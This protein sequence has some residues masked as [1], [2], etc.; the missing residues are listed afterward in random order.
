MVELAANI[1]ADGPSSDPYEPDKAQIRAWGTWV[2]G[3]INAFTSTGGL[4]YSSKAALDADL[5]KPANSM[6]WVIGDPVAAD[7][8]VYGKV[9]ASGAGSWT[10]RSDLPFSFIVASDAGAGTPNTIQAT[11]SIPVSGSALV[12]MNIFEANT[13]SPVTVSFNSG[14]ALTIKTNSGDDVV[15]GGL[16]AGMIVMGI[17]SGST[18]RLVSDQASAAVLAAAEAAKNAAQAAQAAAEAA[19]AGV[20]LPPAVANTYL[21]QKADASGYETKTSAQVVADLNSMP[22]QIAGGDSAARNAVARFGDTIDIREFGFDLSGS[23]GSETANN[24]AFDRLIAN[25]TAN[26]GMVYRGRKGDVIRWSAN[27]TIPRCKLR[28]EGAKLHWIGDLS[29][30][31]APAL[32]LAQYGDFDTLLTEVPV[33]GLFRRVIR[34][35]GD[36]SGDTISVECENQVNN[37]GGNNLDRA[38]ALYGHRNHVQRVRTKNVDWGVL[39][40]GDGGGG[41]PQQDTYLGDFFCE[42]FVGGLYIRNVTRYRDRG[43]LSKIKSANALP[44]PG[45]NAVTIE[46]AVESQFGPYQLFD[47][48]EHNI[49]FG[50]RTGGT[51]QLMQDCSL[52]GLVSGRSGQ[53]GLKVWSGLNTDIISGLTFG[54]LDIFD[55]GLYAQNDSGS[56][57]FND[58]GV[59]IQAV[60]NSVFGPVNIYARNATY[61]S[62]DGGYF[63]Q[64][65]NV[66]VPVLNARKASRNG[67]RIS[68]YNGN[69]T[70]PN[71]TNTLRFGMVSVRDHLAEGIYVQVPTANMRDVSI[72]DFDIVGGTDV[73]RWEGASNRAAQPCYFRGLGRG[74]SGTLFNVPAG[75]NLKTVS[76]W[77]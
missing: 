52:A 60:R 3:I 33:G 19:A 65:D 41:F 56:P 16:T 43:G 75:T 63:S 28:L 8:G 4:I 50:H 36:N 34:L 26:P 77:T 49:R 31:A 27:K 55:C 46:G 61:S 13:A 35:S 74:N 72:D 21:R 11:T 25:A 66:Q 23:S 9:G 10:R 67:L 7:N 57:G 48:G 73:V 24:A 17:V 54:P 64:C 42:S 53:T 68:Q 70:D 45:H 12:W 47:S 59:M 62:L 18:F 38:I 58:F 29:A 37:F 2:E 30:S 5:S 20:T 14:A 76:K 69:N 1:W 39:V 40:Y 51:E 22:V 44:N 32:T 6:A 71:D 15:A